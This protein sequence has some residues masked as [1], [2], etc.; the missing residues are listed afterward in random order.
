MGLIKKHNDILV[1]LFM[2]VYSGVLWFL[3]IVIIIFLDELAYIPILYEILVSDCFP[4][5]FSVGLL[6][7]NIVNYKLNPLQSKLKKFLFVILNTPIFIYF[8]GI[9]MVWWEPQILKLFVR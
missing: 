7:C 1:K 9:F 3:I 8:L 4:Y 6:Y 2:S 5:I